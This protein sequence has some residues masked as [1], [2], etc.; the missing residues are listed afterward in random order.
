[1]QETGAPGHKIVSMIESS[2][3]AARN[4]RE[5][6]PAEVRAIMGPLCHELINY[7]NAEGTCAPLDVTLF[8]T[9]L[10]APVC[11]LANRCT[12]VRM[13]LATDACSSAV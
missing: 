5:R 1:M 6:L 4:T 7:C 2:A 3:R 9:W 11:K 10:H 13:W 8:H 12:P